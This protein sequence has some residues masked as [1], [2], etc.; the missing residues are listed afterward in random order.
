MWFSSASTTKLLF[1]ALRLTYASKARPTYVLGNSG[2]NNV[3]TDEY[4]VVLKD[5]LTDSDFAK[6]VSWVS[7]LGLKPQSGNYQ[8]KAYN[9]NGLRA[10]HGLFS[11]KVIENITADPG[12]TILYPFFPF[13][14][15][16]CVSD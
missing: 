4:I 1:I 15:W 7:D 13:F 3:I 6:H 12:V 8:L 2:G 14:L 16:L 10:C 11:R 5:L 9:I